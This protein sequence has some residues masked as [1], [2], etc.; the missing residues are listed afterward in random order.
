MFEIKNTDLESVCREVYKFNGLFEEKWKEWGKERIWWFPSEIE[1]LKK[2]IED[3]EKKVDKISNISPFEKLV[4][5]NIKDGLMSQKEYIDCFFYSKGSVE[6]LIS[7]IYN[8]EAIKLIEYFIANNQNPKYIHISEIEAQKPEFIELENIREEDKINLLSKI[9]D[10]VIAECEKNEFLPSHE[11]IRTEE[12]SFDILRINLISKREEGYGWWPGFIDLDPKD[13]KVYKENNIIIVNTAVIFKYLEHEVGHMIHGFYSEGM[14][15]PLKGEYRNFMNL[16]VLP[17]FEGLALWREGFR[18]GKES[19][20]ALN[21]LNCGFNF[22]IIG[23][24]NYSTKKLTEKEKEYAKLQNERAFYVLMNNEAY[25]PFLELMNISKNN[26]SDTEIHYR[27][28]FLKS[29]NINPLLPLTDGNTERFYE[30][31]DYF[32]YLFGFEQVKKVLT[33]VEKRDDFQQEKRTINAIISSGFWSWRVWPKWVEYALNN[34]EKY[35]EEYLS[36]LIN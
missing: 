16:C 12:K 19:N 22:K 32:S 26:L 6:E 28:T 5:E 7:K 13:F 1:D 8:K 2:R 4:L 20:L 30:L 14:P 11:E 18:E 31:L 27:N 21:L 15:S 35:K 10:R 17:I 33:E 3:L 34:I 23:D 25:R 36:K 29:H 9:K 24:K